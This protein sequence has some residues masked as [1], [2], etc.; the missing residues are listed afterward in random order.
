[1]ADLLNLSQI[2]LRQF[3]LETGQKSSK[4]FGKD[5]VKNLLV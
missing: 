3:I 4:N 2:Y 5:L 1:M